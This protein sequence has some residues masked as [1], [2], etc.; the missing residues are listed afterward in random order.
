MR[1]TSGERAD[2]ARA[3]RG[4]TGPGRAPSDQGEGRRRPRL[5][6]LAV[7]TAVA[8]AVAIP[9][10]VT[11]PAMTPVVVRGASV[12]LAAARVTQAGGTVDAELHAVGAVV[13]HVPADA[14][15]TLTADGLTVVADRPMGLTAGS[16]TPAAATDIQIDALNPGDWWG[17]DAGAGVG[18]ALID[19]G[20][21]DT[22]DLAG[23][24]VRGPDLSGED[25][26]LDHYGHGT[27]MA[28][29]IAG[30][31]SGSA[32]G[33]VRHVG[34][35]PAAHVVSVKVTG[36]DGETDLSTVLAGMAWAID[37][38]DEHDI[39]V[40]SISLGVDMGV[41]YQADPLS[42]AVET[43]WA[44]GIT[45]VAAA[46]NGGNGTVTSPGRDP[47][48]VSVGATDTHGTATTADDT[49]ADWSGQVDGRK[50]AKPELVAPGVS[51][52]SLRAPGSTVDTANP[53]A[54]VDGDYFKGSGTS[55]STALAAGAAAA[56]LQRHPEATPDDVKGALVTAAD[57][58]TGSVGDALD[59]AGADVAEPQAG[60]VQRHP[61]AF[62]ERGHAVA[63]PWAD[64]DF[65]AARWS[66]ARWSAARW[67]AA[68]WSA[69]RW[70]DEDWGAARWSASRWSASRWSA[71]RWSDE[72]WEAARWSAS[73]WSAA[74]WSASRWSASRWSAS[75]WSASRW[76]ASRWSTAGW[77]D[78]ALAA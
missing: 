69:S 39:G 67:S 5:V 24:L 59:L 8:G 68:R 34:A 77:G 56:L 9:T 15:G 16:F 36:A 20:V 42:W 30:D 4:P 61:V 22:P 25:D 43:A 13:A 6:A 60:W 10:L 38:A 65:P 21:A 23:R 11:E 70:S 14:V 54:R 1:S 55:M 7:A 52:V 46:G 76:S 37:H 18:V 2:M 35:A 12:T 49:L 41:P 51:V 32:A 3:E 48:V 31:G 47:W 45:V 28:G 64:A 73:R 44:H 57:P 63:M 62:D 58:V 50:G 40:L 53:E 29:L 33:P 71:S 27:F 72:D 26:G 78:D 17:L 66:A 19:T 75:R 74:R